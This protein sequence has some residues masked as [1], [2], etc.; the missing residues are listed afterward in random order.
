MTAHETGQLTFHSQ[1]NDR[2]AVNM[3]IVGKTDGSLRYKNDDD[4]CERQE[5]LSNDMRLTNLKNVSQDGP[6][7]VPHAHQDERARK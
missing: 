6:K 3:M 2:C 5:I 4:L 7:I 1:L